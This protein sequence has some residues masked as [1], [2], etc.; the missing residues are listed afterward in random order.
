LLIRQALEQSSTW[1]RDEDREALAIFHRLVNTPEES[2]FH[3]F[4][5]VLDLTSI[6]EYRADVLSLYNGVRHDQR[7]ARPQFAYLVLGVDQV[8]EGTRKVCR[9]IGSRAFV[10]GASDTGLDPAELERPTR[11]FNIL[12]NV[13]IRYVRSAQ[14]GRNLG[15]LIEIQ[16]GETGPARMKPKRLSDMKNAICFRVGS[17]KDRC[18]AIGTSLKYRQVAAEFK[19]PIPV[20]GTCLLSFIRRSQS[21]VFGFFCR[22]PQLEQSKRSS[23]DA[24]RS[25]VHS[26]HLGPGCHGRRCHGAWNG[27][28][29]SGR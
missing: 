2:S 25:D 6:D 19:H 23:A 28:M 26:N 27:P 1:E 15:A 16:L 17:S 29:A 10:H 20:D 5:A 14:P 11:E 3:D 18:D 21:H 22:G 12:L 13:R 7:E 4:K 24:S 8:A 9:L